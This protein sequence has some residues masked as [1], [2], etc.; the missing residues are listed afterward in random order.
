MITIVV[1][2]RRLFFDILCEAKIF[3]II[4]NIPQLE[5]FLIYA[6]ATK[7][8]AAQ[9]VRNWVDTERRIQTKRYFPFDA[10]YKYKNLFNHLRQEPEDKLRLLQQLF[11]HYRTH[12]KKI[13]TSTTDLD[14]FCESVINEFSGFI[15]LYLPYSDR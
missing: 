11:R 12:F 8:P 9:T 6:G 1:L 7:M 14:V 10:V 4:H 5:H 2:K 3:G 15:G 13:N